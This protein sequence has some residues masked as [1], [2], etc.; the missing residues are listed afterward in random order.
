LQGRGRRISVL[1]FRECD[2]SVLGWPVMIR[3]L[4]SIGSTVSVSTFLQTTL[5]NLELPFRHFPRSMHA[6]NP[7]ASRWHRHTVRALA[8]DPPSITI[9][10]RIFHR[11]E[12]E[13]R[14]GR[15][16]KKKLSNSIS[17]KFLDFLAAAANV[18]C[19]HPGSV[20]RKQEK[21]KVERGQSSKKAKAR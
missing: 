11:T 6:C 20:Q 15:D 12:Q 18:V 14:E 2:R 19:S 17:R 9:T 21:R 4:G 16:C 8:T 3:G 5:T 7:K 1:G 13:T 10:I